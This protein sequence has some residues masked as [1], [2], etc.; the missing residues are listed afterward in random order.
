MSPFDAY[1]VQVTVYVIDTSPEQAKIQA[2]RLLRENL[3]ADVVHLTVDGVVRDI[4]KGGARERD[5]ERT[6]GRVLHE[7]FRGRIVE[8]SDAMTWEQM[9]E[10][11][12][13]LLEDAAQ[14]VLRAYGTLP[15]PAVIDMDF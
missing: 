8:D 4:T 13:Q 9:E 5:T 10:A 6:P 11:D 2:E 15:Y 3:R 12:R 1:A 14:A 7:F